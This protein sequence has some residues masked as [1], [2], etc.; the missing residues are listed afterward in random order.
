MS[1]SS[2]QPDPYGRHQLR[3]WDGTQW[4]SMVSDNGVTHDEAVVAPPV[5][6]PPPQYTSAAPTAGAAVAPPLSPVVEGTPKPTRTRLFVA[7]GAVVLIVAAVVVVIA[8]RG[9]GGS[10][11]DSQSDEGKRYVAAIVAASDDPSFSAAETKCIAAGAV[12]VIG[13]ETL[14]K[15]GVTPEDMANDTA[16]DLLP[17]FKPTQAQANSLVD[18]MFKC[19]DFGAMF[20]SAMGATGVS[21]P[22]D[23]L[24]CVGDNL[25][26]NQV[27]RASL[28]ASML[29]AETSTTDAAAGGD[30]DSVM[31]EILGACGVKPAELGS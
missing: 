17:G 24:H 3:W 6:L 18:M 12:D 30:L 20:A 4:T 2:W 27:F 1:N 5:P 8:T 7:V 15:A 28:I 26:S 25:E 16:S 29:D 14:Q 13:V 21:V 23:K 9:G 10:T 31:L 22:A 19:V 11:R